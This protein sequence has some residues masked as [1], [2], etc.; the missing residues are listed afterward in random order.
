MHPRGGMSEA[1]EDEDHESTFKRFKLTMKFQQA[2]VEAAYLRSRTEQLNLN[3]SRL[4]ILVF[5]FTCPTA[6]S[7]VWRW[8]TL[9]DVEHVKTAALLWICVMG[10]L[11]TVLPR[12]RAARSVPHFVLE[13]GVLFL[14]MQHVFSLLLAEP[15]FLQALFPEWGDPEQ[16]PEDA[17][18]AEW[19][20]RYRFTMVALGLDTVITAVH[21]ALPVRWFIIIWIDIVFITTFV[22]LAYW[23]M[24]GSSLQVSLLLVALTLAA[25]FGKRSMEHMDRVLFSTLVDERGKRFRA[26]FREHVVSETATPVSEADKTES[27]SQMER[28]SA[29]TKDTTDSGLLFQDG[30]LE[31]IVKLGKQE[32][33]LI[34]PSEIDTTTSAVI[35]SGKCGT[36]YTGRFCK[37]DVAIKAS[38]Q[39]DEA[40]DPWSAQTV[41]NEIR[42]LRRVRHTNIALFHGAVIQEGTATL[43][44]LNERGSR[45][46]LVME[47]IQGVTLGTCVHK[48]KAYRAASP[49]AAIQISTML[50]VMSALIYLH[51][52]R[53]R[54]VH[55][56]L[57]PEN[58]M[59]ERFGDVLVPKLLDFG[60]S[61]IVTRNAK[62]LGGTPAYVAPE[63]VVLNQAYKPNPSADVFSLGRVLFFVASG[64]KPYAGQSARGMIDLL[65]RGKAPPP[66][67]WEPQTALLVEHQAIIERCTSYVPEDRPAVVEVYDMVQETLFTIAASGN[68]GGAS[69]GEA[70][71]AS[72]VPTPS[73]RTD[74]SPP[75]S[76]APEPLS[77]ANSEGEPRQLSL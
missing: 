6:V 75:R 56:D 16:A 25:G 23:R 20:V 8:S 28:A 3:I 64:R 53:P 59:V 68:N 18:A 29:V 35:G 42:I 15:A 2:E 63:I 43:E 10:L 40:K 4:H 39:D 45:L 41:L 74:N 46:L 51:T 19:F 33:W 47:R 48:L 69:D 26:E 72:G 50:Q 9:D 73:S 44:E 12:T 17:V 67:L 36:V 5:L 1:E 70:L 37:A 71:G 13:G 30:S 11:G 24:G 66:L 27:A 22:I 58:I 55:A 32:Q 61:R 60:L 57:K 31:G 62:Q 49:N 77:R 54:I 65:K 76:A 52:R 21:L 7:K 14:A 34:H 38:A